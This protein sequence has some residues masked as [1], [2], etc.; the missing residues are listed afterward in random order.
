MDRAWIRQNWWQIGVLTI[1]GWTGFYIAFIAPLEYSRSISAQRTTGLGA[2]GYDPISLWQQKSWRD[3]FRPRAISYQHGRSRPYAMAGAMT[4]FYL[5]AETGD[6][7]TR[8]IVL[9]AALELE[10]KSP[11]ESV[12]KIRAL[13][14]RLGGYL[15]GSQTGD[16]NSAAGGTITIRVP[17]SRFEEARAELKKLALRVE[18]E[19]T[20]STD[21]TKEYVDREARL[22]NLRA[23]EEQYLGIMKRAT[24][25]KDTLDVSVKLTE[26]RGQ[27]EQQQA[28][29]A[30]MARQVETA[31]ISVTLHAEADA[32]VFGLH[33]R[34]LYALKVAARDGVEALANYTSAM[35]AAL[36]R[37]PAFL[38]WLGTIVAFLAIAWRGT[39][40]VWRT[41]FV[42]SHAKS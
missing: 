42:V 4:M 24:T 18:S 31:A 23:Q 13:A 41:F 15:V 12:E 27:I 1:A 30:A 14:Q 40:W 29:F 21:V 9:A 16:D 39:R 33:W 25:V 35:I 8:Q 11:A 19:K 5:T 2:V 7:N 34:P 38:L 26:V 17:V 37:L 6:E 10:V 22:R 36:F 32:K 3:V 28:E 20:D